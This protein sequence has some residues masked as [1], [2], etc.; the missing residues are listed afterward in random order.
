MAREK[1]SVIYYVSVKLKTL[2][3]IVLKAYSNKLSLPN[4]SQAYVCKLCRT[5][6]CLLTFSLHWGN[7]LTF[8]KTPHLHPSESEDCISPS[9]VR[10]PFLLRYLSLFQGTYAHRCVA[11]KL[12][13]KVTTSKAE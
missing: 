5:D 8:F 6:P 10:G 3:A 7:S 13:L 2:K 4:K 9:A 11:D 12:R 1:R